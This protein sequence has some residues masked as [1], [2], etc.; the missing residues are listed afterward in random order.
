M[1]SENFDAWLETLRTTDL[2]QAREYLANDVWDE[3]QEDVKIGYC[4][5]GIA[6]TMTDIGKKYVQQ[7]GEFPLMPPAVAE[8]LGLKQLWK[9]NAEGYYEDDDLERL[10][11]ANDDGFDIKLDVPYDFS[12]K[13]RSPHN[14]SI[15]SSVAA[16][17]DAGFSFRQIADMIT[18]FGVKTLD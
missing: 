6:C 14:N 5:L 16:L 9:D 2:P 13:Y 15:S 11:N 3:N 8:W 4:C 18:Y 12:V 10:W 17:N 1:I 7:T